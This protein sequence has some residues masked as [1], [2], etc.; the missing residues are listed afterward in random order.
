LK[1]KK[2]LNAKDFPPSLTS[3]KPCGNYMY[4]LLCH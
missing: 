2:N 3:L 4:R 1:G